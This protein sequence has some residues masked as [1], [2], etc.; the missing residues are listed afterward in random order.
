[1]L[2]TLLSIWRRPPKIKNEGSVI[3]RN[4]RSEGDIR[5]L[6]AS[7]T[8]EGNLRIEGQDLGDAVEAIF[9]YREYEWVWT[10]ARS[11]LPKLLQALGT[12]TDLLDTLAQQFRGPA[13]ANLATFLQENQIPYES[14]SRIGD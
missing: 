7:F 3:L 8:V 14:W 10:I 4:E 12:K 13:A 11:D 6:S 2:N 9:G 1:M 5:H